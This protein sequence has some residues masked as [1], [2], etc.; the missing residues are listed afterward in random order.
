MNW[1]NIWLKLFNT[2]NLLGIDMGFWVSI[3]ITLII[4]AVMNIIFWSQKTYKK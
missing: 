1:T 3:G 2:T 4:V